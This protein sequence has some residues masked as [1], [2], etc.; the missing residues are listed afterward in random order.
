MSYLLS[1]ATSLPE[2]AYA[3]E[4]CWEILLQ[5]GELE[6]LD[7]RGRG[8]LRKV[9]SPRSAIEQRY[10]AL[11][12]IGSVFRRS[13]SDL[14]AAFEHYATEQAGA[15]VRKA[16]AEAGVEP[17]NLDALMIATCTGYLCPGLSSHVAQYLGLRSDAHLFDL[18]G[19]GCGAA[20]PLLHNGVNYLSAYPDATVACV[21]VE[22]C[23]AAFYIDNDPGVLI[24]LC[25]FGDGA[26][27]AVLRAKPEA[28]IG[29]FSG[30]Q[31]LHLPK[32]R[33]SLRFTHANGYLRNQLEPEVPQRAAEAVARLHAEAALPPETR[34]LCHPGGRDVLLA[35]E[36]VLGCAP[37]TES[38]QVLRQCGN[39][40]SPSI[41]F[42]LRN[43]LDDAGTSITRPE[44]WLTAFGAGFTAYGCRFSLLSD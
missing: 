5:S 2:T 15:A 31:S 14:N 32:W 44:A 13:S 28:A 21:A 43:F 36:K 10:F 7:R 33:E 40:S 22:I 41:L 20:L 16:L 9:L 30:F 37:L 19:Q 34:I 29:A 25:L 1:L 3:P 35:V 23:S 8:I 24:S 39:M 38:W 18:V 4:A 27:A 26:A 17:H 12:E 6:N 42:A 11:P